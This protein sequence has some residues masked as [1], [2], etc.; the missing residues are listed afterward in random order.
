[1]K[2][3]NLNERAILRLVERINDILDDCPRSEELAQTFADVCYRKEK[4]REKA[5][6]NAVH[7]LKVVFGSINTL[8]LEGPEGALDLM[9]HGRKKQKPFWKVKKKFKRYKIG[10]TIGKGL[11]S[12]VKLGWDSKARREVALKI[13]EQKNSE[14]AQQEIAILKSLKHRNILYV[15]EW[16]ES[17]IFGNERKTV[18]ALEYAP[19]G[20]LIDY[21]T[22]TPKF[23]DRLAR[24]FFSGLVEGIEYCHGKNLIHRDL[25]HDNCLLGNNFVLK[26]CDFGFATYYF[27]EKMTTMIGTAAYAAPEVLAGEHYTD[28]VDFFSMGIMLF[29]AL[30]GTMPWRLANPKYDKWFSWVDSGEWDA[31]F[32]YHEGRSSHRFTDNQK[33]ILMGL[34]EPNPRKRWKFNEI[35][36]CRWYQG[37]K[38]DQKDVASELVKRK[39]A[40]DKRMTREMRSRKSSKRRDMDI[41]NQKLPDV[42]FQ[43]MLPLSFVTDKKAEW[44][45]EDIENAIVEL[46]GTIDLTDKKNY[47]L[48]FHVNKRVDTGRYIIKNEIKK[49]EYETV[50]VKGTVQ[51]WT[52]PGQERALKALSEKTKLVG[53]DKNNQNLPLQ[54]EEAFQKKNIPKIK[55]IAI[56]RSQGGSEAKFLFSSVYSDILIR[57]PSEIIWKDTYND[58]LKE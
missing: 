57:L 4:N 7:F 33:R 3:W 58:D 6:K 18:F 2:K 48:H 9:V 14:C 43:S 24:W 52:L 26:I 15:Y 5:Y 41:F 25:K 35:R 55:S 8:F 45:L 36:R 42:Y 11:T 21:L 34:L 10:S 32:E 29:I 30:A 50:I 1:M 39:R 27:D 47:K 22:Y 20:Q 54:T 19:Y 53:P 46:R 37:R 17:A 56:F 13:I 44:A 12:E 40:V 28:S 23:G 38:F 49:K 31:F 16:F 51:M